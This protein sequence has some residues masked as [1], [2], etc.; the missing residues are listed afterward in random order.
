VADEVETDVGTRRWTSL[1][2][3]SGCLTVPMAIVGAVVIIGT[4]RAAGAAIWVA[5]VLAAVWGTLASLSPLYWDRLRSG[6][7]EGAPTPTE[8]NAEPVHPRRDRSVWP[9]WV[10]VVI[11]AGGTIGVGLA[12]SWAVFALFTVLLTVSVVGVYLVCLARRRRRSLYA[13]SDV[14]RPGE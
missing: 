2:Q 11:I 13:T 4:C 7:D 8:N 6:D 5:V 1:S 14:P 12:G 10:G 9:L 3:P